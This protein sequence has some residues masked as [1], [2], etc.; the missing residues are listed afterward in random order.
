[1]V[2]LDSEVVV[3][4]EIFVLGYKLVVGMVVVLGTLALLGKT[5]MVGIPV[6]I[7]AAAAVDIVP[8][9]GILAPIAGMVA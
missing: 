4:V 7:L 5:E 6:G 2:E 1:M 9:V 8:W 3:S